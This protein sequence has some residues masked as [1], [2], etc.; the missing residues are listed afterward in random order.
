M[1]IPD[2]RPFKRLTVEFHFN[3]ITKQAILVTWAMNPAFR[4][5]GPWSFKLQRGRAVDDD[6]WVDISSTTDQPWLY[7]NHPSLSQHDRTTFYRVI[8]TDAKGV[9]YI[10]QPVSIF[11]DWNHYDWRLMREIVRKET[12]V[13]RKKGGTFGYLLKR[14]QWGQPCTSC[15]DPNSGAILDAHCPECFGTGIMGG[16]YDPIVYYMVMNPGK[17]MKRL[18]PDQGVIADVVETGRCLAWPVP[19]G[20]DIWVQGN[21]NRRYRI[22]PDV[23]VIARHRGIDVILDVRMAELA[24]EDIVYQVPTTSP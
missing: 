2:V 11:Q 23:E 9:Q 14:R 5:P 24:Q 3:L 21:V 7:D 4:G 20:N 15:V 6:Q 10:S 8:L 18:T 19:E 13:Q 17:R 1:T 12:L 22:M 16:Y